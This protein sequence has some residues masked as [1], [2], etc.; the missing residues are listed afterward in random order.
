[1]QRGA[2]GRFKNILVWEKDKYRKIRNMY[3]GYRDYKRKIK[4][5]YPYVN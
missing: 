4:G 2:F 3:R 1:M 5:K